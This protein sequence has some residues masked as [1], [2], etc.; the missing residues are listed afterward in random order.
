MLDNLPAGVTDRDVKSC[1]RTPTVRAFAQQLMAAA[2]IE[3][4]TTTVERRVEAGMRGLLQRSFKDAEPTGLTR[5]A[6]LLFKRLHAECSTIVSELRRALKNESEA[7]D[8]A[9]ATLARATADSVEQYVSLLACP[10]RA[11]ETERSEWLRRY[12]DAF[13]VHEEIPLPDLGNRRHMHYSKIFVPPR[14]G[15]QTADAQTTVKNFDEFIGLIDRT[16]LL[17]DPGAGPEREPGPLGRDDPPTDPAGAALR[18]TVVRRTGHL[19]SG[20][21]TGLLTA[22][23]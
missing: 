16:V 17:G 9:H 22:A 13:T 10:R 6:E 20:Q 2:I 3:G 14:V 15:T 12:R 4:D 21:Y 7:V 11:T 8:W 5:Y 18:A 23:A 19:A 1:L